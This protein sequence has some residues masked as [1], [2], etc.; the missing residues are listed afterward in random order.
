[1]IDT[2]WARE[3]LDEHIAYTL[4]SLGRG[5]SDMD[6][7]AYDTAWVARLAKHFPRCGFESAL[8]W[9][10]SHQYDDGSWGGEVLHYHDRM[11]CTLAAIVTL[12]ALGAGNGDEERIRRGETFLWDQH[13][14]LGHDA[15]DTIAYPILAA[16]L[17]NEARVVGLDLPQDICQNAVVVE[18]KLNLL[19]QDTKRWRHTTMAFSLESIFI[20]QDQILDTADFIEN[21][22]SI[23]FSPAATAAILLHSRS[24]EA[25][26]VSYLQQSVQADGGVPF[27]QPFDIFESAWALNHLRLGNVVSPDHPDIQR[28]LKFLYEA[29]SPEHGV[30]FSPGFQVE[31]LDDTAV[32]FSV[33]HWGGYPVDPGV[34]A[35]YEE[36]D[37]FR[38]YPHETDLSLS[39]NI[40]TLAA[41]RMANHHSRFEPWATKIMAMLRRQY[42]NSTLWFDKWHVSPYYLGAALIWSLLN[43]DNELLR[44]RVKWI[45]RTQRPDG[46]WGYYGASTAEETA[47]CLQALLAWDRNV[48]RVEPAIMDQ[49]ARYLMVHLND[50]R[51]PALWI[52]KCL[53]MPQ[54]IV[55]SALLMALN[56]YLL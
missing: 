33:L 44:S 20:F 49:A 15:H 41:L 39:V 6:S 45:L 40:R 34:F 25:N 7:C 5:K 14:R 3:K 8:A 43:F 42:A 56:T 30:S 53:Y 13:G 4:S 27:A 28:I 55:R 1:M 50:S 16:L 17:L 12:R 10:R 24:P 37:Y 18:K 23:G 52:G 38:C 36:A 31:D 48:E 21:N 19:A 26:T 22:G 2:T 51:F 29:W 54:H 11:I 46:G 32:A 47:Y 9:L 35:Y